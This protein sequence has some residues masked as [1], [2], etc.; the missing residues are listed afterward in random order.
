MLTRLGRISFAGTINS[1]W[2]IPTHFPTSIRVCTYLIIH[3]DA[4]QLFIDLPNN[5]Q[6]QVPIVS[7]SDYRLAARLT[8][9]RSTPLMKTGYG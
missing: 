4:F 8:W 6:M 3:E 7:H 9:V 1:Y 2:L 5:L